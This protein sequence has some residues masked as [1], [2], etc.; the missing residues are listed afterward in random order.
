MSRYRFFLCLL[1]A[2]IALSCDLNNFAPAIP[3]HPPLGLTLSSSNSRIIASFWAMNDE[4][5][6]S[7]YN[8]YMG[9]NHTQA[10]N[11][12]D[13]VPNSTGGLPS[14]PFGKNEEVQRRTCVIEHDPTGASLTPGTLWYI[15]VSAWDYRYSTNSA[16]GEILS[17][18]VE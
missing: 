16:L 5:F 13:F 2:A 6:F 1:S 12:T 7:G 4:E 14:F 17:I 18:Q 9:R 10:S 11:R 15:T 8:V 3:L